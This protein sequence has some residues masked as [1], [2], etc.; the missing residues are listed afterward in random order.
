VPARFT[1]HVV[2]LP[3]V[4]TFLRFVVTSFNPPHVEG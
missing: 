1:L 2:S 4:G 3:V